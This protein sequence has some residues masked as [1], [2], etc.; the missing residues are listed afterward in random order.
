M[1]RANRS[2]PA[3]A[4]HKK[5]IDEFSKNFQLIDEKKY[6]KTILTFLTNP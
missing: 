5:V 3:R 2:V 1:P 6:G 4:R